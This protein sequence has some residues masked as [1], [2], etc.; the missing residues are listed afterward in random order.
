M[1]RPHQ[2]DFD[3]EKRAAVEQALAAG[4]AHMRIAKEHG[5]NRWSV[6]RFAQRIK[7]NGNADPP[8][9]KPSTPSGWQPPAE[10]NGKGIEELKRGPQPWTYRLIAAFY[11]RSLS[12]VVE[13]HGEFQRERDEANGVAERKRKI[14]LLGEQIAELRGER[15]RVALNGTDVE[16]REI[17]ARVADCERELEREEAAQEQFDAQEEAAR[18]RSPQRRRQELEQGLIDVAVH[19]DKHTVDAERLLRQA[20]AAFQRMHAFVGI[21]VAARQELN[22][23]GGPVRH[24]MVDVSS[25][26]T[27]AGFVERWIEKTK[28]EK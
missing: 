9:P 17:T 19:L 2:L 6:D 8:P 14:T 13:A 27:F 12:S 4:T 11:D 26:P 22:G 24:P 3:A 20:M 5:L 1:S 7:R 10:L 18:F 28:G 25:P 16:H 21:T 15:R 23:M